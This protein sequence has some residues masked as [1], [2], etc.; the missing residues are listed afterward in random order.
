MSLFE[1]DM[2]E[3]D[4]NRLKPTIDDVARDLATIHQICAS[5]LNELRKN[6]ETKVTFNTDNRE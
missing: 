4:I 5:H 3:V 2:P 6:S 1:Q